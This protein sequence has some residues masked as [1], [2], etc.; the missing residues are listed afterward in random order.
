MRISDWS[1]D[2]CSSDLPFSD[3]ALPGRVDFVHPFVKA[4]TLELRKR[5]TNCFAQKVSISKH[6]PIGVV[7][8]FEYV[9]GP[10]KNCDEAWRLLKEPPLASRLGFPIALVKHAFGRLMSLIQQTRK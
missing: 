6:T 10:P 5:L 8:E 1:S 4:L 7:D 9:I 3:K 2:V